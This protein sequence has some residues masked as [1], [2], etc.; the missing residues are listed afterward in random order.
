[1]TR[2]EALR[3]FLTSYAR[4]ASASHRSTTR[5]TTDHAVNTSWSWADPTR[6]MCGV[7]VVAARAPDAEPFD[8]GRAFACKNC[9]RKIAQEP[10]PAQL[11]REDAGKWARA[12]SA[13]QAL[14]DKHARAVREASNETHCYC[15]WCAAF[16]VAMT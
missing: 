2:D 6:A 16:R 12:R 8:V 1:M 7:E 5:V 10:V 15:E 13:F 11:A 3:C 4:A 9:C 14:Y